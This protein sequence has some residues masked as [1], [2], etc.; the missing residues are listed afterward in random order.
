M[1][2]L[3]QELHAI[4]QT[5]LEYRQQHPDSSVLYCVCNDAKH[6]YG[7]A[8]REGE[9]LTETTVDAF[10]RLSSTFNLSLLHVERSGTQLWG[11]RA[12]DIEKTDDATGVLL[13]DLLI[14]DPKPKVE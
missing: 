9:M 11:L 3:S 12:T 5:L 8:D 14:E 10:N 7:F 6:Y 1:K 2:T 13:I 4:R